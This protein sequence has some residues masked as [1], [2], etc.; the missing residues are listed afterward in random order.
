MAKVNKRSTGV[1][2]RLVD[3]EVVI[4]DPGTRRAFVLNGAASAAWI[5]A[6]GSRE[7]REIA[8]AVVVGRFAGETAAFL[9]EMS[10]GG[11]I[12][13]LEFPVEGAAPALEVPQAGAEEP[14]RLLSSEPLEV[15][16][17]LCNSS[18][19]GSFTCRTDAGCAILFS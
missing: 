8:A 3:G 9:D 7:L 18:R 1:A 4:A 11:L 19:G 15:L 2:W 6:D 17:T 12:E 10:R 16:A 13:L 14:P 5:L